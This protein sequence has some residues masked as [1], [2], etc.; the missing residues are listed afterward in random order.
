MESNTSNI[1]DQQSF[2]ADL[3]LPEPHFDEEAT[4]LSARP[5]V[6]LDRVASKARF[7]RPWVLGLALTGALLLGVSATAIYYS[8]LDRNDSIPTTTTEAVDSGVQAR[9]TEIDHAR[10]SR[11]PAARAS[12]DSG[13]S[14][15][16]RDEAPLTVE[17]AETS[18]DSP[19]KPV[20]RRVAVLTFEP[21]G[22]DKASRE[23]RKAARKEE[24]ERK[25]EVK[26]EN[27]ENKSSRD[28]LRIRE[29]FEGPHKP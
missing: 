28:L 22:G 4:V 12:A 29:I 16:V 2:G 24:R 19:R 25:R 7:S 11:P 20:A 15:K 26:R 23:E 21:R 1:T 13:S 3:P 14:S 8:R 18:T 6:P 10:D 27:Q 17:P 5:V 9:T